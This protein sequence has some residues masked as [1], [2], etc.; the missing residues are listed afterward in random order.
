MKA[1]IHRYVH[2]APSLGFIPAV[3]YCSQSGVTDSTHPPFCQDSIRPPLSAERPVRTIFVLAKSMAIACERLIPLAAQLPIWSR[4]KYDD[5]LEVDIFALLYHNANGIS[6][7]L[8]QKQ[9]VDSQ[10]GPSPSGDPLPQVSA[11]WARWRGPD[12][13]MEPSD[14][15]HRATVPS[16]PSSHIPVCCSL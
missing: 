10:F 9:H 13:G 14:A 6:R 7:H 5:S 3:V 12:K 2:C 1:G 11:S 8:G 4:R 15:G 16:A